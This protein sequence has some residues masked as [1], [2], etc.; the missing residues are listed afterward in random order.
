MLKTY[1]VSPRRQR[2]LGECLL[3]SSL[4]GNAFRM[5]VELRGLLS[6]STFVLEAIPGKP[7]IKDQKLVFFL[8]VYQV[9]RDNDIII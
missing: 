8:S 9:D 7:D 6:D 1:S 5:L 2:I 4:P 3:I